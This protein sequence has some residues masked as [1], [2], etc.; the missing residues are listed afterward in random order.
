MQPVK[1]VNQYGLP[2]ETMYEYGCRWFRNAEEA[3]TSLPS[4]HPTYEGYT[5]ELEGMKKVLQK[6]Y[7]SR[8]EGDTIRIHTKRIILEIEDITG[9]SSQ[10]AWLINGQ[11][12]AMLN[13]IAQVLQNKENDPDYDRFYNTYLHYQDAWDNAEWIEYGQLY[14]EGLFALSEEIQVL[15][16][17]KDVEAEKREQS[18]LEGNEEIK[19]RVSK[20]FAN[21][22]AFTREERILIVT[23]MTSLHMPVDRDSVTVL[24]NKQWHSAT[25]HSI[26]SKNI[27]KIIQRLELSLSQKNQDP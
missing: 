2:I 23:L 13:N 25:V 11:V 22:S 21:L 3:V 27:E 4:D 6:G 18:R 14:E 15:K 19:Q 5:Q 12:R 9:I 7:I 8:S 20:L 1:K 24:T 26:A 10:K 16:K 17:Q